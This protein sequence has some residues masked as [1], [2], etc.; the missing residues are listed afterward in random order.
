MFDKSGCI[1]ADYA[2]NISFLTATE[3]LLQVTR[4]QAAKIKMTFLVIGPLLFNLLSL[5]LLFVG[6]FCLALGFL[7]CHVI[8]LTKGLKSLFIVNHN[9]ILRCL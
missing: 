6:A 4:W 3:V 5:W 1:G 7:F 2:V 8:K 9:H